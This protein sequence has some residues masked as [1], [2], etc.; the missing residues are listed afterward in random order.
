[1]KNETI[2][3]LDTKINKILPE[4]DNAIVKLLS[5]HSSQLFILMI[6]LPLVIILCLYLAYQCYILYN[7]VKDLRSELN[8]I[9]SA[10]KI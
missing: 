4:K 8:S 10:M 2:L 3:A 1:L 5:S 9:K 6:V 7:I